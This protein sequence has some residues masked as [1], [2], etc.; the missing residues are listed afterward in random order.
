[1]VCLAAQA[2]SGTVTVK[3]S[4]TMIDLAHRW[5][6]AFTRQRPDIT[7]Q[8]TGGGSG[9]GLAALE[10]GATDVAIAS[11]GLTALEDQRLQAK[12][13]EPPLAV[14]VA[15][16]SVSF[17]VNVK[18]PVRSLSLEQL[19]DIFLGDATQWA[20][21]GGAAR[22]LVAYTRENTSGTYAFV[23]ARVLGD[24]DFA[25]TMQQLQGT[26]AVVNA[27]SHEPSAIGFGGTAFARQVRVLAVRIDGREV[28]PTPQ[29]VASGTYPLSRELFFYLAPRP[30]AD[31]AAFLEFVKSPEGQAIAGK[32][33]FLPLS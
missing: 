25:P 16:D 22:P 11:R 15:R 9:P 31:A 33:G 6:K 5:A 32:A 29:N 13:G 30:S 17:F 4:D 3:G 10:S 12:F 2:W 18:N 19:R 14:A 24:E 21:L 20:P 7:V 23:R 27:V 28:L 1:M 8:V 26:G